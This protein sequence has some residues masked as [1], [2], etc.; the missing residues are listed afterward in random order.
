M[1]KSSRSTKIA[2]GVAF[3]IG[4]IFSKVLETLSNFLKYS[5]EIMTKLQ[6]PGNAS[7]L[8]DKSNEIGSS[9]GLM[10]T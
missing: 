7:P 10:D 8:E 1:L 4:I 3:M 5:L 9:S 6:S 2:K